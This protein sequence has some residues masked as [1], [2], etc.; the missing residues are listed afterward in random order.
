MDET[1]EPFI[2]TEAVAAG[3]SR[4]QLSRQYT[5]VYRNV[6]VRKGTQ[7]T[8]R[9]R[10][11]AAWLWSGRNATLAGLSA[12]AM[13]GSLWIDPDLPAELIRTGDEVDGILIRR[14][15]LADDE[16]C[17]VESMPT[18]TPARTAYDLG[19][20]GNLTQAVVRLDALARATGLVR[21]DIDP[22]VARHRGARGIVQLRQAL[23]LMDGGAE[24]P[25][26]SRTRLLLVR[27]GLPTP[28]TQIAVVDEFG[29]PYA[30][31]DMGW[32]Q[33]KVGVEYDG[34]QHWLDPRQRTWDI[35]RWAKLAAGGWL[36]VRVSS[37]L[38][39][40]RPGVV[41]ARVVDALR[42]AGWRGEIRLVSRQT[43]KFVA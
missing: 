21:G 37:E 7:L 35:D 2:G 34:A 1:A 33:W 41:I 8:A 4:R 36:I 31:I 10:A 28:Q 5:A 12:A 13:H 29:F 25:Q 14:D 22:V 42:Q 15:R 26:E 30:R 6:Y 43:A 9:S 27:N 32:E 40:N 39:R 24:S 20:R 11:K 3:M 16:Y 19:R 38:L 23:D 17:V 18:T